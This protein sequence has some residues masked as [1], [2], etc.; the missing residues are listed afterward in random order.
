M[1]PFDRL[2]SLPLGVD[3]HLTG[4]LRGFAFNGT[5]YVSPEM[6]ALLRRVD[7][8]TLGELLDGLKVVNLGNHRPGRF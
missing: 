6:Y 2:S 7:S 8:R 4:Y 5:V 3:K 1:N